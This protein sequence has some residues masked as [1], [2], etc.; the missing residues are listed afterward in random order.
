VEGTSQP[1]TISKK[2]KNPSSALDRKRT[3]VQALPWLVQISNHGQA[4]LL[5]VMSQTQETGQGSV[6][7]RLWTDLVRGIYCLPSSI[8]LR[9]LTWESCLKITSFFLLLY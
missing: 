2:W 9:Q 3:W 7:R 8:Y 4:L 5:Y 6:N 1:F